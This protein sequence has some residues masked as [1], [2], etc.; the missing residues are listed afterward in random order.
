M[1]METVRRFTP[2]ETGY[3]LNCRRGREAHL[4]EGQCPVGT[5]PT[6]RR[7]VTRGGELVEVNAAPARETR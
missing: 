4:L 5:T 7:F 6:R 1:N 2:D 3:C